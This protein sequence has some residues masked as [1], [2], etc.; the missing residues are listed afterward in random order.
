M[1]LER[2]IDDLVRKRMLAD[3]VLHG[4]WAGT[5]S[6]DD[7]AALGT[8]ARTKMLETIVRT[9]TLHRDIIIRLAQEIDAL[10]ASADGGE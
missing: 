4:L 10:K 9:F 6:G 5:L 8:D 7:L 2:E 3:P 1:G